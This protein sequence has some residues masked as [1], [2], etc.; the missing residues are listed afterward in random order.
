[1]ST[2]SPRTEI[3]VVDSVTALLSLLDNITSLSVDPPTLYL[4]SEGTRL[5]RHGSISI[6]SLYVVPTK[7]IYLTDIHCLGRAA[8][9]TKTSNGA[10]LQ[11]ILESPTIPKVIFDIRNDPDA[12]FSHYQVFVDGI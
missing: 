7:K 2:I 4:H 1:M 5:G 9:S 10:S 6:I 3:I 11:T 8:F 12:L